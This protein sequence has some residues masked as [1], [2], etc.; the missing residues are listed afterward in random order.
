MLFAAWFLVAGVSWSQT[1]AIHQEETSMTGQADLAGI[2][3]YVTTEMVRLRIPGLALGIVHGDRIVEARGFGVADSSGRAVTAQTPFYIGS[4]TKSFTALAVMQLVEAGRI[5][6]DAPVRNYLPWFQVADR[7]A[8]ERITVRQLLNH[9]TGLSEKDGNQV[10]SSSAGL[11]E[12]VRALGDVPLTHPVGSRFE[13]S[14]INFSIAGLI[15]EMVSGQSYADYV[16]Q[17]ILEPLGM[18]H[19]TA[20]RERAV[21]DGLAEGHYYRFGHPIPGVGPLPP[22]LLPAGL[23]IAS[24]EDMTHYLVAQLNGGRYRSASVLSPGGIAALHAPAAPMRAKGFHYAMGWA[25]GPIDRQ[26]TVRH[27]GDTSHFHSSMMLQL[28]KGWGIVLLANA[29]GFE[30][31]RQVD[32]IARN[33]VRMLNGV[34]SPAPVSSPFMMRALYWTVLL[35]PLLLIAGIGYGLQH[36]LRGA[37]VPPWQVIA[38]VV[39]YVGIASFFLFRLPGLI[40][41]S[42]TSMRV[43]YPELA[44]AVL[45]S[46]V[47]GFGWGIIFPVLYMLKRLT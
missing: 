19:A 14:N 41:F 3:R 35:M 8:S 15:V 11:E 39:A 24:V 22:A 5:D 10:W 13:Y 38:T 6:L 9:T 47:L 4:L 7:Q 40:P 31:I 43:F 33:V 20:S 26:L 25:V 32:E 1:A 42:L 30:Q 46:G 2:D 27:N 36:W 17:H 45:A 21:A 23:L 34:S 44:Y 16:S 37:A 12:E 18:E 29:S 28:E